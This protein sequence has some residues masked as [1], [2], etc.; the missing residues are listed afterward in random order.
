MLFLVQETTGHGWNVSLNSQD[1]LKK[2]KGGGAGK[3]EK[4]LVPTL[5]EKPGLEMLRG[6]QLEFTVRLDFESRLGS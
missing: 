3:W 5:A 2:K 6:K 4:Q 1:F